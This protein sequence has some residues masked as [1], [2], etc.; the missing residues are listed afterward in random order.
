MFG[1]GVL[2]EDNLNFPAGDTFAITTGAAQLNP[3]VESRLILTVFFTIIRAAEEQSQPILISDNL[4][5][6]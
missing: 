4:Y 1:Y 5:S 2:P 3:A 6:P